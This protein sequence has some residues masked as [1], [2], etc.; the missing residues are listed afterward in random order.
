[1]RGYNLKYI[2]V[3]NH[4]KILQTIINQCIGQSEK[5][6]KYPQSYNIP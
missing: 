3:K 2:N 5:M 1:M 4:K 6:N